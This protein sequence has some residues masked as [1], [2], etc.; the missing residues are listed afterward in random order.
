MSKLLDK[1]IT[2]VI[3]YESDGTETWSI[4]IMLILKIV[5]NLF[6]EDLVTRYLSLIVRNPLYDN[7]T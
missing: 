1:Q 7:V 4:L 6:R 5:L 3:M 2:E